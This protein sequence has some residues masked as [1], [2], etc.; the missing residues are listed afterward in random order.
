MRYNVGK[1]SVSVHA[2]K[3]LLKKWKKGDIYV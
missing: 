1:D 3:N 2:P